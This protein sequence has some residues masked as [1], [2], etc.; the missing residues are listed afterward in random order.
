ML[1]FCRTAQSVRLKDLS[2]FKTFDIRRY[3]SRIDWFSI[4]NTKFGV[5]GPFSPSY[6]PFGRIWNFCIFAEQLSQLFCRIYRNFKLLIF[7]E[8]SVESI[9]FRFTT[10]NLECLD[11]FHQVSIHLA[12]FENFA[13]LQ[14]SSVSSFAVFIKISNFLYSSKF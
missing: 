10:L 13:F 14:N 5:S 7:V 9:Y 6:D 8:I 1:H 12:G 2:K 3:F 4:Y 11:H